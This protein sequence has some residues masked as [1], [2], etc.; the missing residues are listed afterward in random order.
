MKHAVSIARATGDGASRA[1][2]FASIVEAVRKAPHDPST[3]RRAIDATVR[4][5]GADTGSVFLLWEGA[6]WLRGAFGVWD[7]TR[8]SFRAHVDE[9]PSVREAIEVNRPLLLVRERASGTEADWYERDGISGSIVAP[10]VG[11]SRAVGVLFV[12]YRSPAFAPSLRE[13]EFCHGV[14]TWW[15]R[16]LEDDEGAAT[17]SGVRRRP[18]ARASRSG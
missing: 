14:A 8:T 1:K 5:V 4:A 11:E 18:E 13:L 10:L 16:A 17:A 15:A 2:L 7:W 6:R 12:D 3:A 9:W